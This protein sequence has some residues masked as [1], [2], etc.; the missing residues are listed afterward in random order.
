MGSGISSEAA[1]KKE[2]FHEFPVQN[3]ELGM[4]VAAS[5]RLGGWLPTVFPRRPV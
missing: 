2:V 3:D 5:C 4:D 1:K